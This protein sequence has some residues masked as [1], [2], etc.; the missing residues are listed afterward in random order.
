[1]EC[2]QR[3]G[4]HSQKTED[5]G[6]LEVIFTTPL[7]L[8]TS[9]DI[10]KYGNDMTEGKVWTILLVWAIVIFILDALGVPL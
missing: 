2:V 7:D 9:G 6:G 5:S 10:S 4:T 3:T 1:M 8:D